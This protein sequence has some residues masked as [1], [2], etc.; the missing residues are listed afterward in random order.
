MKESDIIETI[1]EL[2]QD[3]KGLENKKLSIL[4]PEPEKDI[5]LVLIRKFILMKIINRFFVNFNQDMKTVPCKKHI[6]NKSV[7]IEKNMFENMGFNDYINKNMFQ[8]SVDGY[9]KKNNIM[10]IKKTKY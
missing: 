1:R 4:F 5:N 8:T 10:I 6:F 3:L 9:M 2:K 7:E